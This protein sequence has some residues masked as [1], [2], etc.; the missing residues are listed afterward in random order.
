[1]NTD[2]FLA[3][4]SEEHG[5][6]R[7]ELAELCSAFAAGDG[8][9]S[10]RLLGSIIAFIGPHFR[11]EEESLFPVFAANGCR[12]RIDRLLVERDL[13]IGAIE[14]LV[15]LARSEPLG[16][17]DRT[18]AQRWLGVVFAHLINCEALA[19][20][21]ESLP[22]DVWDA[23]VENRDRALRAHV[24]LVDWATWLRERPHTAVH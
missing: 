24:G 13:A 16:Q 12:E 21:T 6:V 14:R 18:S 10:S 7:D 5:R 1:V 17:E 20:A 15:A 3:I 19:M 4:L 23:V 2:R 8:G 11:Y 22:D 9:R